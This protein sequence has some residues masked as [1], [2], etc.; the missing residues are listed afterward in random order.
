MYSLRFP[1]FSKHPEYTGGLDKRNQRAALTFPNRGVLASARMEA[2]TT[3]TVDRQPAAFP[4]PDHTAATQSRRILWLLPQFQWWVQAKANKDIS[5]YDL[6]IKQ[7]TVLYLVRTQ[8][9]TLSLMAKRMMVAPTVLTGIVDRLER[10]GLLRRENDPTDR[11]KLRLSLSEEGE[12]V[13]IAGEQQLVDEITR[14]VEKFTSQEL[15]EL[16]KGLT[17]IA[18]IFHGLDSRLPKDG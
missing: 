14:E 7:R 3:S 11:R 10:R 4:E 9:A 1:W 6:S 5:G 16:E 13:S 15:D 12:R 2:M 18:R 17:H 8:G